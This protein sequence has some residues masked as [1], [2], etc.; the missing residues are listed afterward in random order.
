MIHINIPAE[1]EI[2]VMPSGINQLAD[3]LSDYL[4]DSV[5]MPESYFPEVIKVWLERHLNEFAADIET[6]YD[7]NIDGLQDLVAAYEDKFLS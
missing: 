7:R 5:E 3:R 6:V 1:V 2:Q 4:G